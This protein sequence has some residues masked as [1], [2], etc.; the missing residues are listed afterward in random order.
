MSGSLC[1]RS[2]LTMSYQFLVPCF[3]YILRCADDS[4]YVGHTTNLEARIMSHSEG[5]VCGY[6]A[7]RL[8]VTMVYAREFE[9]RDEAFRLERQIKGWSR[10]KKE[11]LIE[12]KIDQLKKF[13]SRSKVS[14]NHLIS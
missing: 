3:V 1:C 13:A 14:K 6:T 11:A 8:P 9:T 5:Q 7:A 12:N 2:L 4:Y 10:R